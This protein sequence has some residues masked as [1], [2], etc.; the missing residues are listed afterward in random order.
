MPGRNEP[1]PCGSG[2][3]YKKCCLRKSSAVESPPPS[4]RALERATEWLT[5]R[6]RKGVDA[7]WIREAE[8]LV[9]LEDDDDAIDL[10]DDAILQWHEAL[11]AEGRIGTRDGE[12]SVP[13]LLLGP[14]G[15]L[16]PA[17]ERQWIE[18][19][20]ATPVSLYEVVESTPGVGLVLQDLFDR[21]R[22]P[23]EIVERTASQYLDRWDVVAARVVTHNGQTQASTLYL[24]ERRDLSS[25]MAEVRKASAGKEAERKAWLRSAAIRK[26][27]L[28]RYAV[29]QPMPQIVDAAS[30][31]PSI[32]VNDLYDV[33]DRAALETRLAAQKDVVGDAEHG[34]S[35]LEDPSA[36]MSRTYW[37][38]N[39][40][41]KG[42]IEIFSRAVSRADAS[43]RWAEEVLGDAV[44][45][46]VRELMDPVALLQEGKAGFGAETP[47]PS[48]DGIEPEL[49]RELMHQFIR[50]Y[51]RNW[52]DEPIPLLGNRTPRQA[53]Q[54]KKGR[55]QV[56]ELLKGYELEEERKR[57]R[58]EVPFDYT[59][60]W[61]SVGLD[62]EVDGA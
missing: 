51:Y 59:F 36:T 40:R 60:L 29:S 34:W 46:V 57:L 53:M 23:I 22:S 56:I 43:R 12:R 41:P 3:K 7:A 37:G 10:Q 42:R 35:R 61:H 19:I 2:K 58:G 13:E 28:H 1:C 32:L 31:E 24:F 14:G 25:V 44:E 20:A 6:H 54:T 52:A 9:E 45:F 55:L 62:P 50:D 18:A 30:G 26:A 15:P 8:I 39:P 16:F 47:P 21:R 27:W 33:R 49:E 4:Q 48:E 38:I 17:D 5:Q 11:L